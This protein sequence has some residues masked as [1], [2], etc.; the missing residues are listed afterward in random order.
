VLLVPEI[1][2]VME[3]PTIIDPSQIVICAK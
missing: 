1:Q 3:M 2:V